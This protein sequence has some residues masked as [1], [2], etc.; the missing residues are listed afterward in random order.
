[1]LY[2]S[3]ALFFL[4]YSFIFVLSFVKKFETVQE[5][6]SLKL[7]CAL[8]ITNA[9]YTVISTRDNHSTLSQNKIQYI[10]G[11]LTIIA[12]SFSVYFYLDMSLGD[13][14]TLSCLLICSLI[15]L[16]H[17]IFVIFSSGNAQVD[18]IV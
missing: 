2:A 5:N 3:E 12:L 13:S 4:I 1:M 15:F 18:V 10:L 16:I 7:A 6:I 8:G 11:V 14:L 9:I 17:I